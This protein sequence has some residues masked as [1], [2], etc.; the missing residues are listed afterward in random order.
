MSSVAARKT[1][2]AQS[3]KPK[4]ASKAPPARKRKPSPPR[5]GPVVR[6]LERDLAEIERRAP[7]LAGSTLAALAQTFARELDK[8][9]TSTTAKLTAARSLLDTLD[10]LRD[11]VPPEKETDP[12]D[13]LAAQ[14]AARLAGGAGT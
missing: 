4:P 5:K 14:R 10:R 7:E 11:Q 8:P 12:L 1:P 13:D 9:R 2:A 3:K 6:A